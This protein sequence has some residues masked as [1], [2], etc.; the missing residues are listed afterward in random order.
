[1]TEREKMTAGQIYTPADDELWACTCRASRLS[2]QFNS[3]LLEEQAGRT[4]ILRELLGHLGEDSSFCNGIHFDYGFNTYI[5]DRVWGNVNLT[6]C[7]CGEVHIGNDVLIGPNV[8]L[9]TPMHSLVAD[10]RIFRCNKDGKYY[11]LEYTKPITIEDRV[12]IAGN[13]T[14]TGG[15]TIGYGAVIGAGSV[16]T[17]DIP[18][19]VIAAGSPCRVIRAVTDKDRILEE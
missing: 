11:D 14:I 12:W 6:V 8:S 13:V 5:G 18:P 1:M 4:A 7:D 16:V 17:R 19:H 3:L 9:L 2:A 10:E 15:V